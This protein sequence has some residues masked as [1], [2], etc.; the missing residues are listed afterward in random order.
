VLRDLLFRRRQA[1]YPS[2]ATVLIRGMII[3]TEQRLEHT[4]AAGDLF[5]VQGGTEGVG[6]LDW[7]KGR[8]VANAAYGHTADLLGKAGSLKALIQTAA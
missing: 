6:F 1:S 5:A 3:A 2:L 7:H 8:Q 4:A